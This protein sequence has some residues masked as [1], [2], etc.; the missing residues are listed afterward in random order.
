MP[1]YGISEFPSPSTPNAQHTRER[2]REGIGARI[3]SYLRGKKKEGAKKTKEI[4]RREKENDYKWRRDL[5]GIWEWT[6]RAEEVEERQKAGTENMYRGART[7]AQRLTGV[8]LGR[9][10]FWRVARNRGKVRIF[11]GI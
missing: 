3:R 1:S 7:I 4:A 8:G 9:S 5:D 10:S 2:E 11:V 6:K